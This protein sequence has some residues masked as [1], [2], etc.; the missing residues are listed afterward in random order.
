M[1]LYR[2]AKKKFITDVSGE[3]ARLYGGRWNKT[4][5]AMLYCSQHLSLCVLE[6]LVHLDYQYFTDDHYFIETEIADKDI[7]FLKEIENVHINWRNN[8]PLSSTQDYGS[9]WLQNSGQ[10]AMGV[11]S[12]VL[13]FEY[14]ILLNPKHPDFPKIKF[15]K[16]KI[17]DID[18]RIQV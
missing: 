17:L 11:P 5:D 18:S 16:E 7:F 3:G 1:K 8:P 14:N 9:N 4:G 6:I 10:L 15:S 2:I 13:P 12:A